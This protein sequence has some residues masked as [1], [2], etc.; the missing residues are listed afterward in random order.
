MTSRGAGRPGQLLLPYSESGT[1]L[2]ISNLHC[3]CKK[4]N[5]CSPCWEDPWDLPE[6]LQSSSSVQSA[7]LLR[8][9]PAACA[10][11]HTRKR[12]GLERVYVFVCIH[13]SLGTHVQDSSHTIS[14]VWA[15]A[16]SSYS[17][18]DHLQG[19]SQRNGFVVEEVEVQLVAEVGGGLQQSVELLLHHLVLFFWHLD[20]NTHTTTKE[21]DTRPSVTL[22]AAVMESVEKD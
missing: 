6:S 3:W 10:H 11:T 7:R 2:L 9:S 18:Y 19:L 17:L 21:E 5:L 22:T 15:C 20:T 12:F 8:V 1:D 13:L 14:C 4:L 16:A